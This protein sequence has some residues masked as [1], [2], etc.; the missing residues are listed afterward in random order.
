VYY[1][2]DGYDSLDGAADWARDSL[3]LHASDEREYLYTWKELERGETHDDLWN[4]GQM[5]LVREGGL[6]GFV[7]TCLVCYIALP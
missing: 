1:T 2:P 7:S 5:Q 4:A 6:H 3:E